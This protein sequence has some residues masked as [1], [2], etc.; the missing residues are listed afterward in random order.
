MPLIKHSIVK[1]SL[2]NESLFLHWLRDVWIKKI[3]AASKHY[4]DTE[5]KKKEKAHAGIRS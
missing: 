1:Y 5:R 4:L 3:E 2:K